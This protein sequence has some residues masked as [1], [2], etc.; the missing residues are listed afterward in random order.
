MKVVYFD[1][2]TDCESI[3]ALNRILASRDENGFNEFEL[4][5]SEKCP[6]LSI[7]V[8][9]NLACVH[10]FEFEDDCGHYAYCDK[11][12]LVEDGYTTFYIGSTETEISNDLVIP[13]SLVQ[14][15]AQDFFLTSK[16]SEKLK[17][18]EL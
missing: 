1:A 7:L 14:V 6:Y 9:D 16:M 5:G 2:E 11:E 12:L 3:E 18:F 8:N 10:F 15:A 4:Y 13:F 17:W